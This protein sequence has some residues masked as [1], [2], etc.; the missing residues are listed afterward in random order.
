M[1]NPTA[2]V[3][4]VFQ[5]PAYGMNGLKMFRSSQEVWEQMREY[6]K[7]DRE[8]FVAI[9][10]NTKNSAVHTEVV[11]V[12]TVDCASVYP[13]EIMKLAIMKGA[14]SIVLVHNHPTGDPDPSLADKD[15]TEKIVF[16]AK[17][18]GFRVLDHVVIGTNCFYSFAD[19]GLISDAEAKWTGAFGPGW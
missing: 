7:A 3:V 13:R 6:E 12:G 15:I 14:T 5:H 19:H 8:C 11:S 9:F 16:A 2:A 18:L 10:L 17:I 1:K 4:S